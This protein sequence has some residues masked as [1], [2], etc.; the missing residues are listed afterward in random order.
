MVTV[1]DEGWFTSAE[2]YGSSYPYSGSEGIDWVTN[3]KLSSIDYGTVHRYPDGWGQTLDWGNTWITQHGTQAANVG[4]P[5]VL[6]EFG[7]TNT[8]LRYSTVQG[9]MNSAVNNLYGGVQ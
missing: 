3:L 7:T 8:G 5:V 9:W 4:K 2:G 6:E 1:G